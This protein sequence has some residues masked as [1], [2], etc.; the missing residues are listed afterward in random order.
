MVT[1]GESYEAL[2][3]GPYTSPYGDDLSY[4][5]AG[6]FGFF[7]HGLL[8][9]HFSERG[10]QGRIVR[11]ADYTRV[12]YAYGVDENTGL[13]VRDNPSL[14][15]VEME[16]IGSGGVF[17]FDL[18]HA[19][20]GTGSSWAIYDVLASYLTSGDRYRPQSGQFVIGSG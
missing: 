3:Y 11:L 4:D 5:P 19:E 17:V 13:L 20:R 14:G 8:D 1:G 15:E 2:R 10:R 12:R 18:G 7:S 9:T 16:V 6:G